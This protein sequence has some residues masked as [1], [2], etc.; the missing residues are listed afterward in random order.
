MVYD[1]NGHLPQLVDDLV[2]DFREANIDRC[3]LD[4]TVISKIIKDQG[5]QQNLV[6][7]E[8]H[9]NNQQKQVLSDWFKAIENLRNNQ[10]DKKLEDIVLDIG[11]SQNKRDE[12]LTKA[13][14]DYWETIIAKLMEYNQKEYTRLLKEETETHE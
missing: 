7:C 3:E 9:R 14:R 1:I 11:L 13:E 12:G 5:F 10:H 8:Q 2:K 6:Q 4:K